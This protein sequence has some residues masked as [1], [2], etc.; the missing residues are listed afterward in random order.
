MQIIIVHPRL[1][2]ARTLTV[3]PGWVASGALGLLLLMAAGSGL[4]SYVTIKHAFEFRLP[5]V[6]AWVAEAAARE[7]QHRDQFVRQNLDALAVK[8]GQLQAQLARLDAIG[9]RVMS[10][11]GLRVGDVPKAPPGRGGAEPSQSRPLSMGEISTNV[12][13]LSQGMEQRGD[14]LGLIESGEVGVGE[15][16]ED[17]VGLADAAVPRAEGDALPPMGIVRLSHHAHRP[18]GIGM[19]RRAVPGPV[20]RRGVI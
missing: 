20:A 12:A 1:K 8:L 9:E 2:R 11:A 17:E 3:R 18:A 16:A 19:R 7:L 4:L 15:A 13:S 6:Q 10:A 14:Q 5:F